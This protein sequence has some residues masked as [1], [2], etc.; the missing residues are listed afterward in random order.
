MET[1]PVNFATFSDEEFDTGPARAVS[2]HT[3]S[4]ARDAA[5]LD[6]GAMADG[7]VRRQHVRAALEEAGFDWLGYGRIQRIG[8]RIGHFA[9][10]TTFAPPGWVAR[11]DRERLYES[12]PR[13][14]PAYRCDWPVR[15]DLESLG[16][17]PEPAASRRAQRRFVASAAESGLRSGI[18]LGLPGSKPFEHVVVTLSSPRPG[19]RWM[20]DATVG[21]AYALA[22]ALHAYLAPRLAAHL[23]YFA[24]ENLNAQQARIL[25]FVAAGLSKCE[26]AEQ[27]DVSTHTVSRRVKHLEAAY[28]AQNMT[29]LAYIAGSILAS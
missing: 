15:W 7:D 17:A 4:A 5:V 8:E 6:L 28:H 25:K 20:T 26:M 29:Q 12:D 27:L 24:Y 14:A 18:T 16:A 3:M 2:R 13:L 22:V 19:R 11:Y 1:T 21:Q 23:P 9:C 10:L